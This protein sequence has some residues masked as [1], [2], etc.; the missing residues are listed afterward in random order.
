MNYDKDPKYAKFIDKVRTLIEIC[1]EISVEIGD[2]GYDGSETA[3]SVKC[4]GIRQY[5][6]NIEQAKALFKLSMDNDGTPHCT[7][8]GVV[9]DFDSIAIRALLFTGDKMSIVTNENDRTKSD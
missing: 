4:V 3:N 9:F 2:H 1:D 7:K 5:V 8:C 6:T